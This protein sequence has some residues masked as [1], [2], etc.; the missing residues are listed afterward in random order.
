MWLDRNAVWSPF[1]ILVLGSGGCRMFG[2]PP[3]VLILALDGLQADQ[4]ESYG[5]SQGATPRLDAFA[6]DAA[7]FSHAWSTS[8]ATLPAL[9]S[10]VTSRYPTSHGATHDG[11]ALADGLVTIAEA[12]AARGYQTAA[13]RSGPPLPPTS[14]VFRG[15]GTRDD[16]A[17]RR[18]DALTDA[19]LAWLATIPRDQ[20][21]HALLSYGD[22]IPPA[23]GDGGIDAVAVNRGTPP[24]AAMIEV[25]MGRAAVLLR[26]GD[27]QVGRLLDGLRTAGRFEDALVVVA[28]THGEAYGAHG[29]AGHGLSL[30]DDVIRVPLLVRF[31]GGANGGTVVDAPAS[32]VDVV[33]LV[34]DEVGLGVPDDID[35]LRAGERDVVVAECPRDRA[36]VATYGARFDRNLFTAIR[37]PWKLIAS[38]RDPP[39]LY[40]LN[41]PAGE[42][43][44][45]QGTALGMEIDLL[46]AIDRARTTMRPPASR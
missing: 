23:R 32:L 6:I 12:L 42:T 44:N 36:A 39:E 14:G 35:G 41:S 5:A 13:F 21:V 43:V 18:A 45:R 3:D 8:C 9:A 11:A 15:Y 19:A 4:L 7:V 29:L 25:E 27:E 17:Q 1:L 33:P 30:Y 2:P 26:F 22:L 28:G 10:I 37:W 40:Q 16:Q 31:P 34:L 38:D 24:T 20:P 46:G